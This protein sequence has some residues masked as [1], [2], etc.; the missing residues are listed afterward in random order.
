MQ[1]MIERLR[2]FGAVSVRKL[3]GVEETIRFP[4]PK[5]LGNNAIAALPRQSP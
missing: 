2:A 4:L 5:G 1:Q 3:T